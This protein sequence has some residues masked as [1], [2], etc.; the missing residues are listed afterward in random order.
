MY[1]IKNPHPKPDTLPPKPT[2]TPPKRKTPELIIKIQVDKEA[3][4]HAERVDKAMMKLGRVIA[5]DMENCAINNE[6]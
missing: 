6:E 4:K 1:F 5:D 3:A 2:L